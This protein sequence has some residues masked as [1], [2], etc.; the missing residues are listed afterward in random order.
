MEELIWSEK[1]SIHNEIVDAQHQKLF[2]L[3]NRVHLFA[4]DETDK[5]RTLAALT[6]YAGFHFSEEERVMLFVGY[7][8]GEFQ[9]HKRLHEGF[10][11]RVAELRAEPLWTTLDFIREWLLMHILAEDSK[12]G[13]FIEFKGAPEKG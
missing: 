3:Y 2:E 6:E 13:R 11:E 10:V 5:F 9:K 1:F 4:E 12:I 8:E 7:P